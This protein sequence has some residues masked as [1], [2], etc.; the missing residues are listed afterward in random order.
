[1]NALA[2][3]FAVACLF[4]ACAGTKTSTATSS[5]LRIDG[6]VPARTLSIEDVEAMASKKVDWTQEG[7]T[8]A[9][10]AVPLETILCSVGIG[11]C[12]TSATKPSETRPGWEL[13]VVATAADGFES[14]FSVAEVFHE[15][16]RTEAYVVTREKG[17]R[18]DDSVGPFRL[19]V[20]TDAEGSRSVRKLERLTVIDLRKV[21][22]PASG[23]R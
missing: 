3:T 16:G 21:F 22:R 17:D 1:M 4:T 5:W 11:P 19:I 7:E 9:Y 10:Q 18:L 8:H 23:P 14:V 2:R 6:D 15:M 13:A 12:D 20:P